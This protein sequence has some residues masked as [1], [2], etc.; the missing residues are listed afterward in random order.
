MCLTERYVSSSLVNLNLAAKLAH[1]LNN[2][3]IELILFH[4]GR[5]ATYRISF[6]KSKNKSIKKLTGVS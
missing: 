6:S 1:S 2:K 4:F 5:L 3:H